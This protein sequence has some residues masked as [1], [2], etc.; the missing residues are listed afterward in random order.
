MRESNKTRRL[1]LL[2]SVV[3]FG[4]IVR[5]EKPLGVVLD[6][7]FGGKPKEGNTNRKGKMSR[8]SKKEIKTSYALDYR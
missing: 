2:G 7:T 6:S 1:L 4:V 3:D 5:W 8:A